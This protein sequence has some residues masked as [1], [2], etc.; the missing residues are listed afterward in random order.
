LI[1]PASNMAQAPSMVQPSGA[2]SPSPCAPA[3]GVQPH[4]S[5]LPNSYQRH[6][7]AMPQTLP[8]VANAEIAIKHPGYSK[9]DHPLLLFTGFDCSRG[10]AGMHHGTILAAC[11]LISG[12][13]DGFLTDMPGGPSLELDLDDIV[14]DGL[15]YYTVPNDNKYAIYPSFQYWRFPH[16]NLPQGWTVPPRIRPAKTAAPS[17]SGLTRAVLDRDGCC[18]LSGAKDVRE[19]AHLCPQRETDW[20]RTNAM[21]QYNKSY[22]KSL[23]CT[24]DDMSNMVS[25]RKDIHTAFDRERLFAIVAK[26]GSWLVHFLDGSEDLCPRYHNM[27][28]NLSDDI[29][30]E[31]L[32]T[33][34]AWAIFP[35]L[36]HFLQQGP[37]RRIRQIVKD[38]EGSLGEET[39][40]L[41]VARITARFFPPRADSPKKRGRPDDDLPDNM[42]DAEPKPRD[43]KKRKTT[44][45]QSNKAGSGTDSPDP[46]PPSTTQGTIN[47]ITA[48][49][50]SLASPENSLL[51]VDLKDD[52]IEDPDP[53]IHRFYLGEDRLDRLRRLELKRRRP[54]HN[55]E[56]FCCD[57]DKKEEV[58]HAALKDEGKWDAYDLCDECLGGEY[59][60]R[61]EDLD[62]RSN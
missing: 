22:N 42:Q 41:D 10:I 32:L 58:V 6:P 7:V 14:Q 25:L 34:F 52:G 27:K 16:R 19:R 15:Y 26:E 9:D 43:G 37:K 11:A 20:F 3:S 33:R 50:T 1:S 28:A 54:Y 5:R 8:A 55:P 49:T 24:T 51:H 47:S 30:P 45:T 2:Q 57:Y 48:T 44:D 61:A 36:Q 38:E 62:E 23:A 4:E 12:R 35:R 60:L 56:L 18:L 21:T 31:H 53:R 46:A 39:E 17:Q 29:A 13:N 40:D 59:L